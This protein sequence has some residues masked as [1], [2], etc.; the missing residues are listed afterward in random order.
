[1]F[2]K[3]SLKSPPESSFRRIFIYNSNMTISRHKVPLWTTVT[4]AGILIL[5][6][7]TTSPI[8]KAIYAVAFFALVLVFMISLGYLVVGLQN[9]RV[10]Q[11]SRYRIAAISLLILSLLMLRST[12]SLNWQDAVILLLIGFGLVFYISRR[13]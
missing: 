13:S 9:G 10:A 2:N 11:K 5:L 8:D 3:S 1:M 4:S 6:L 12:Q 7:L